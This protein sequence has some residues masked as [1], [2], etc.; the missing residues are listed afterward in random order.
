[1]PYKAKDALKPHNLKGISSDQIEQHW[2][3]YRGYVKN[4]NELIAEIAGAEPG[5]RPWAEL[6]RRAGFEL[7]GVVLHEYYFENLKAG[8]TLRPR[9]KLIQ[10]LDATWKDLEVWKE[11]FA[12]TGEIRG[13]GWAILYHDPGTGHL[14]NWWVSD[15]ELGHPAG[16]TPILVM[17]VW[18][19][20]YMVDHG[21]GGRK[22][23]I[24]A[25]MEN[26]NWDA[27]ERRFEESRGR[28]G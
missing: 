12:H 10:A 7:D 13:V 11:D 19:H 18:E 17:D 6:K 8:T 20:A 27:V 14:F 1:M 16:F 26:V 3:L 21:A 22:D 9:G 28:L 4:V 5:S 24:E 2:E 15:H 23:Y 25:F